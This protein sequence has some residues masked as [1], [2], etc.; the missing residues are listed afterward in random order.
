MRY[1]EAQGER[2]PAL[3]FGTWELEGRDAYEG[4]RHA[5]ELGYRHIDTARMYANEAQVGRAIADA[6]VD[7]DDVFLTT[8]IPR[9][10]LAPRDVRRS[11]EA[12]LRDL[13]TDHVDLLLIHW[14]SDK[15]P[16]AATLEAM[17]ALRDEGRTR[18]IGVSNFTADL[19]R[20]AL[21]AT[22]ILCDQVEY[23]PLLDQ[24]E[25]LELCRRHDLVLTAYSPLAKGAALDHPVLAAIASRHGKSE[26][27]VA[28]RWLLQQDHVAAIPRS[29][30]PDH[31]AANLAIFDFE[32]SA[33]EVQ[34]IDDLNRSSDRRRVDPPWAPWRR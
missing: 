22:T 16:V 9:T 27:Q 6:E 11:T 5:L 12:S 8:K 26:A 4:V 3:G 17:A 10:S 24:S 33:D 29:A 1:V 32:L 34:Q 25:V 7:R 18:H 23:H 20:Q 30:D 13:R 28:L 21:A 14:P 19:L 2:V 31:R 15:V